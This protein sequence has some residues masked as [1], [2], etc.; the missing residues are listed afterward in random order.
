MH[1][2]SLDLRKR[3]IK[4]VKS[5]MTKDKA[6]EVYEIT[7]QTIYN[8]LKLEKAQ[9]NLKPKT[10]FQKGHSH[11]IKDLAAF[12]KFVD[13]HP[14]YTQ[15]EMGEYFSVGSSTISRTLIKIGYTRKKRAKPMQNAKKK[16]VKNI[17][18]K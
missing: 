2:Y 1:S 12:R 11:G 10:G 14:D 9:G 5:N 18:K 17:L 15:E 16:S 4:A 3:V 7:K 8:W 6:A 13:Q